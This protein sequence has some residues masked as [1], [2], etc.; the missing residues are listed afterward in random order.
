MRVFL[1]LLLILVSGLLSSG[2]AEALHRV[3]LRR[4]SN[5]AEAFHYGNLQPLSRTFRGD[6]DDVVIND[7]LGMQFYGPIRLGT[8]PREFQVIFDTGS[9]NLWVPT[10]E[11]HLCVVKRCYNP[12]ESSSTTPDGR[13]FH[14]K[15]GSGSVKGV[16][17]E[18]KIQFASFTANQTFAEVSDVSGLG[19]MYVFARWDG[20]MGMAWPVLAVDNVK[21]P[22]FSLTEEDKNLANQFAFYLPKKSSEKGQLLLGGYD[23][24]HFTGKLVTVP[25]T[26]KIYW[27]VNITS[28]S[29]GSA[30]L[31][32]TVTAIVD[33]GT[34]LI[35]VP[36]KSF[37]KIVVSTGAKKNNG[38][39][40]TVDCEK[41]SVLPNIELEI[42][43]TKWVFQGKDYII[44]FLS[45]TCI[46]GMIPIDA[47][48][49]TGESWILGDVFLMHVY[50]VFDADNATLSFAYAK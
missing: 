41:V 14:I 32:D 24:D 40:Y 21:P 31:S 13:E 49:I 30:V 4:H 34:S 35:V 39:L 20:I 27:T 12:K 33:S 50:T 23:N 44:N 3:P 48:L 26:T 29:I 25:L 7:F 38:G 42:G 16:L 8:P 2:V 47:N 43:G 18:D 37:D 1:L 11:T 5:L 36:R 6:H 9:S 15:Y 22:I 17:V 28:S 10:Q 19:K 46:L 45:M